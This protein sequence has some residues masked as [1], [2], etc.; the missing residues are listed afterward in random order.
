MGVYINGMKMP[1]GRPICIVID[2]AG[3]VRRYDLNNDK[4][5]DNELFEAN[6]IPSHGRLID[7]DERIKKIPLI[8]YEIYEN[9]RTLLE[10]A[11]T[12]IP[13]D[14]PKEE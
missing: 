11:P 12:V 5:A 8:S 3:Q 1:A 4:Y 7:A 9:F 2:S 13:A 14:P 10:S 6:Y